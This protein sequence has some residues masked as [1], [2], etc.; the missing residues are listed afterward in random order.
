MQTDKKFLPSFNVYIPDDLAKEAYIHWTD[1][2]GKRHHKK[3]GINRFH[4][5]EERR[6]AALALVEKLKAEY[7]PPLPLAEKMME[8]VELQSGTWKRKTHQT[9]KSRVFVFLEWLEFREPTQELMRLYFAQFASTHHA[10]THNEHLHT[11]RRLF[12]W[13]GMSDLL[14]GVEMRKAISTPAK[15][16]Q[17]HQIVRIKKRLVESDPALWLA[18]EFIYYC[19]IRPGELAEVESW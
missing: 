8:W 2:L 6:V 11:L 4:S 15:Y 13:L 18:C 10:R 1:H 9:V 3:G 16:F 19:F 17:T 14:E 5:T 12:K 7:K